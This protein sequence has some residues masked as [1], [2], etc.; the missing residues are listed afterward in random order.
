VYIS[1][2]VIGG[3]YTP[4]VMHYAKHFN[5]FKN[6]EQQQEQLQQKPEKKKKRKIHSTGLA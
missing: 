3:I 1:G 2:I 6:A 5:G 4:D